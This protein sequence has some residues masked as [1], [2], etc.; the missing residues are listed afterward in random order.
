LQHPKSKKLK[1]LIA[2]NQAYKKSA[3]TTR[4]KQELSVPKGVAHTF[5]NP[6]QKIVKVYNTHQPALK[7]EEYFR[8]VVK[9]LDKVT[10]NKTR[11]FEMNFNAKLH[12]GVLMNNYRDEIIAVN[13][14]DLAV[15]IMGYIGK[16]KGI[17]F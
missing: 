4:T 1:H 12:L 8:D 13:P 16:L 10:G 14:P 5:R 15:R 2:V 9:L 11:E 3:S 17:K 6:T 7:M